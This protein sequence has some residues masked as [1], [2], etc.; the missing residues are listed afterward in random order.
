MMNT[1]ISTVAPSRAPFLPSC[2][3]QLRYF[4]FLWLQ[5]WVGVTSGKTPHHLKCRLNDGSVNMHC[6]RRRGAHSSLEARPW[7]VERRSCVTGAKKRKRKKRSFSTV[8]RIMLGSALE[9]QRSSKC[10]QSSRKP[11][12]SLQLRA[13]VTLPVN[14]ICIPH[15]TCSRAVEKKSTM[16]LVPEQRR[17]RASAPRTQKAPLW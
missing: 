8:L 15:Q 5:H 13:A 9:E 6:F 17:K 7:L 12:L 11:F 10:R 14:E 16:Q 3:A 1:L 2:A 4:S